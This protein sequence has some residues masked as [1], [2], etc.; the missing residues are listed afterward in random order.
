MSFP[1]PYRIYVIIISSWVNVKKFTKIGGK[2][3][4]Y[5]TVNDF[6]FTEILFSFFRLTECCFYA[7]IWQKYENY[8]CN[9][10]SVRFDRNIY[11]SFHA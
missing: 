2:C 5:A 3:A 1:A 11:F 7:M 10:D 4:H 9:T 8:I 6:G